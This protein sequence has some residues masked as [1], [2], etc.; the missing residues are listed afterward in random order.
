MRTATSLEHIRPQEDAHDH[1]HFLFNS[2]RSSMETLQDQ[3]NAHDPFLFLSNCLDASMET[4]EDDQPTEEASGDEINL[5]YDKELQSTLQRWLS[6]RTKPRRS[7]PTASD[8]ARSAKDQKGGREDSQWFGG[9]SS[10]AC[11]T[12]EGEINSIGTMEEF[13]SIAPSSFRVQTGEE[14]FLSSIMGGT[15]A[16]F[17]SCEE[18]KSVTPLFDSSDEFKSTMNISDGLSTRERDVAAVVRERNVPSATS[19]TSKEIQTPL[20]SFQFPQELMRSS[21]YSQSESASN[22]SVAGS[23]AETPTSLSLCTACSPSPFKSPSLK[24]SKE[25]AAVDFVPTTKDDESFHGEQST[26]ATFYTVAEEQQIQV[27]HICRMTQWMEQ[28][29]KEIVAE[30]NDLFPVSSKSIRNQ[31]PFIKLVPR[32]TMKRSRPSENGEPEIELKDLPWRYYVQVVLSLWMKKF[33]DQAYIGIC[34]AMP[35]EL[36]LVWIWFHRNVY[37]WLV[38][39]NETF[40]CFSL[41]VV[42]AVGAVCLAGLCKSEASTV[43][44]FHFLRTTIPFRIFQNDAAQA[45]SCPLVIF[46]NYERMDSQCSAHVDFYD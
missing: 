13:E 2:L 14:A 27:D 17:D 42:I 43:A 32:T 46:D 28:S 11:R 1:F 33:F 20:F 37:S 19:T 8:Y 10:H 16:E 25:L 15:R 24:H 40:P 39:K 35:Y 30:K 31:H 22:I 29:V 26:C 4:L 23:A 3:P 38:S 45:P 7:L 21:S 9:A 5:R 44:L 12:V 41:A 34:C 36:W 6:W 18:F